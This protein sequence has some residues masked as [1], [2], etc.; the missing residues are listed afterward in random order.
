MD[1][2]DDR[3]V[4]IPVISKVCDYCRHRVLN[5]H[6]TCSA[7]PNGIPMRIWK[8]E[9]DHRRPYRGDHGIRFSSLRPE[10]IESI[11]AVASGERPAPGVSIAELTERRQRVAS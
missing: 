8:G 3:E 1:G 4:H 6:R 11:E 7:F 2:I 5:P 10:D 9:H